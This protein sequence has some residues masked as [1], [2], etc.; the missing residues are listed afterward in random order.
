MLA[1]M[2]EK[3][4]K[5]DK[6]QVVF[7]DELPWL[8]TPRSGFTT[9]FE[10]FWNTWGCHRDNLMLVVCGSASSWMP[11]LPAVGR[12]TFHRSRRLLSRWRRVWARVTSQVWQRRLPWVV[13]VLSSGCG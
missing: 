6:R 2:L 1:Q 5:D 3:K 4:S 13:L 10:G 9:A 12:S 8:D 11:R 7:I